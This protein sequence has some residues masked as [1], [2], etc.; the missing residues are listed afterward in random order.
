MVLQLSEDAMIIPSN[1]ANFD[2]GAILFDKWGGKRLNFI[3]DETES[4]DNVFLLVQIENIT[5]T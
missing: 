2:I 4:W 3:G 1:G 5:E